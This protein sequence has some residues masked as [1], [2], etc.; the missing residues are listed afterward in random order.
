M[1]RLRLFDVER[2]CLRNGLMV[3]RACIWFLVHRKLPYLPAGWLRQTGNGTVH[4]AEELEYRNSSVNNNCYIYIPQ[5]QARAQPFCSPGP[6]LT[7]RHELGETYIYNTVK[8][9]GATKEK[10]GDAQVRTS[11][12]TTV[13]EWRFGDGV[14]DEQGAIQKL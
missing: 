5:T 12:Q 9:D 4:T 6:N 7:A 3:A 8:P 2:L 11:L 14:T 10:V 1:K 13:A